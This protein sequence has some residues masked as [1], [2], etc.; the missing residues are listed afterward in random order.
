MEENQNPN[1][2]NAP[3]VDEE[4]FVDKLFTSLGGEERG[5]DKDLF[6][7]RISTDQDYNDKIFE[8]LGDQ[9][10]SQEDFQY[11]TGIKKKIKQKTLLVRS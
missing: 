9:E 1:P 5:W 6:A 2:E 8:G 7:E 11:A 4:S 10:F 3:V